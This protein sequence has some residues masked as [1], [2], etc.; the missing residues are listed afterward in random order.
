MTSDETAYQE[1][2]TDRPHSHK[3]DLMV[4]DDDDDMSVNNQKNPFL[5]EFVT[6]ESRHPRPGETLLNPRKLSLFQ[7]IEFVS[8]ESYWKD[9]TWLNLIY[10]IISLALFLFLDEQPKI[11]N[12]VSVWHHFIDRLLLLQHPA[13]CDHLRI[14]STVLH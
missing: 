9:L 14:S 5:N 4:Y 8:P 6:E 12:I 2:I 10:V 11:R 3:E 13:Y 1:V 7:Q